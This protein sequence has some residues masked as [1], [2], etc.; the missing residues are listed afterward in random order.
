MKNDSNCVRIIFLPS[1]TS[2]KTPKGIEL[3]SN[4]TDSFQMRVN[5]K[6]LHHTNELQINK[7]EKYT[8][9]LAETKFTNTI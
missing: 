8:L 9:Y 4:Y 1:K 2:N 5:S 7:K 3:A 6:W